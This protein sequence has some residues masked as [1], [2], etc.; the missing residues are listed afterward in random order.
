MVNMW[1]RL[2]ILK[3]MNNAFRTKRTHR[4]SMGVSATCIAELGG[5]GGMGCAGK[6]LLER[7]VAGLKLKLDLYKSLRRLRC[8]PTAMH[9]SAAIK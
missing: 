8:T 9:G 7:R 4:R 6:L 5:V 1:P 2:L 3:M